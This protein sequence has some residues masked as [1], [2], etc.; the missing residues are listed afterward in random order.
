MFCSSHWHTLLEPAGHTAWE[1]ALLPRVLV[2]PF[3][4]VPTGL[5]LLLRPAPQQGCLIHLFKCLIYLNSIQFFLKDL[6]LLFFYDLREKE[7][8]EA[9][10]EDLQ[11]TAF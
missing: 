2:T 1:L 3:R 6:L 4:T 9:E 10:G 7:G 5:L 11:Q 8:R